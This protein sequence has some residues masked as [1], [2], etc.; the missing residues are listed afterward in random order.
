MQGEHTDIVIHDKRADLNVIFDV[1]STS[2]LNMII[3]TRFFFIIM[4]HQNINSEFQFKFSSILCIA[5][6]ISG[7][8]LHTRL[9]DN[10]SRRRVHLERG[11][12]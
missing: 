6:L 2:L 12:S 1:Y 4:F 5:L 9:T 7:L 8:V 3:A 10:S 11:R